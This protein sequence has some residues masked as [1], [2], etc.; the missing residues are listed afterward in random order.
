MK[1]SQPIPCNCI[2]NNFTSP[3]K[4]ESVSRH[5]TPPIHIYTLSR[6][7]YANAPQ[8]E[9]L[10][11]QIEAGRQKAYSY[12]LPM[13]EAVVR[14][15]AGG[16][17][18]FEGI[19]SDMKRR[20][21]EMGGVRARKVVADNENAF[22][23]FVENFY[24]K[25]AKFKRNLLRDQQSGVSLEGIALLGTPHLIAV[26]Q[27]GDTRYVFLYAAKWKPDDLKSYLHLLTVI[28]EGKHGA[29]ADQLWCMDLRAGKTHKFKKSE[30]LASR[31]ADAARHYARVF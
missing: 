30:R 11:R 20:A 31:C 16:G 21:G 29:T 14:F 9:R 13:R 2:Y 28:I 15:C 8:W 25:I 23:S 26:D 27:K 1:S 10:I 7:V 3:L 6:L 5:Q 12:Y 22:V 24:P 18:N 19:L 4:G 17:D